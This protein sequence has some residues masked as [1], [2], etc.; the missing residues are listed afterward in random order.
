MGYYTKK[1]PASIQAVVNPV[2]GIPTSCFSGGRT[3]ILEGKDK[4]RD[5]LLNLFSIDQGEVFFN[6][7]LGSSLRSALFELNDF[8]LQ[9]TLTY[10]VTEAVTKYIP[11]IQVQDVKVQLDPDHCKVRINVSYLIISLGVTDEVTFYRDTTERFGGE[12]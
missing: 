3:V 5:D 1:V 7:D 12:Y 9:D 4:I 11:N 10:H 2:K 6:P 8:V